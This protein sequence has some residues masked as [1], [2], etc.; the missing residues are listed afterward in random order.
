MIV[1]KKYYDGLFLVDKLAYKIQYQY[2][3]VDK[4]EKK[5]FKVWKPSEFNRREFIQSNEINFK[6]SPLTNVPSKIKNLF[7]KYIHIR[8]PMLQDNIEEYEFHDFGLYINKIHEYEQEIKDDDDNQTD[9]DQERRIFKEIFK[10]RGCCL[11]I[12]QNGNGLPINLPNHLLQK[13]LNQTRQE[14][15]KINYKAYTLKKDNHPL[16]SNF[17]LN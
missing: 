6:F 16:K 15:S 7:R 1:D 17:L 14:I 10:K 9:N 13:Y 12:A 8:R 5:V 11:I 4:G 3:N 2:E